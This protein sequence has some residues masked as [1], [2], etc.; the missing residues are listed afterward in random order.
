M[1]RKLASTAFGTRM[2]TYG[3]ECRKGIVFPDKT[4]LIDLHICAT[5]TEEEY[6]IRQTRT[7]LIPSTFYVGLYILAQLHLVMQINVQSVH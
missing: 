2:L 1:S 6:H 7:C 3:T 5:P 4:Q